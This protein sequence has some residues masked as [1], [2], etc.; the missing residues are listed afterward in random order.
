M[1]HVLLKM[2]CSRLDVVH[3]NPSDRNRGDVSSPVTWLEIPFGM[4]P[5]SE[6]TSRERLLSVR[7]WGGAGGGGNKGT[8][9][10]EESKAPRGDEWKRLF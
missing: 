3:E 6:Q 8:A 2:G 7:Y 1:V 9:R 5:F 4:N 10:I